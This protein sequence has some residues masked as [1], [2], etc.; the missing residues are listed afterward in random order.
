M[1]ARG[2]ILDGLGS[3]LRLARTAALWALVAAS[4]CLEYDLPAELPEW[5][6]SKA[7]AVPDPT[8]ED[9]I[10]QTTVPVIDVLFTIDN[11]CSMDDE[12]TALAA[13]FP[14]FMSYFDGS[15]LDYHVGVV[16]TDL[17]NPHDQGRLRTDADGR[18]YIDASTPDPAGVFDQMASMG[19]EGSGAEKGLGAVYLALVAYPETYNAGFYRDEAAIHT[20]VIS[21]EQDQTE[22]TVITKPEFIDW[23]DTLKR[24]ADQRTFSSIVTMSGYDAGSD[25]LD[26]TDQIGGIAWNIV[27]GDW[28]TVLDRLGVQATGMKREYFLSHLP[29]P[30]TIEVEVHDPHGTVLPFGEAAG[31]PPTGGWTY[32]P[33]RNS[34]SFVEFIPEAASRVV[35]RY[36]LLASIDAGAADAER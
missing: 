6:A 32:D 4:G 10:V 15:G 7:P 30:D 27:D 22:T 19:T 34:I 2:R 33:Q 9:T 1:A 18:T 13:N 25:Y 8:Q 11:S 16:S 35:I 36:T 5:P 31:E 24:E 28:A 21:D 17:D 20:V 29:V 3:P 26:V 14:R 12:Q 23:Y